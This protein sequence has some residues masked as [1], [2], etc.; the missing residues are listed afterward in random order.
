MKTT[1]QINEIAVALATAQGNMGAALKDSQNPHFRSTY[2]D[3]ASVV[4]A[5]RPHLSAV[6]IATVQLPTINGD[7][8]EVTTA[9]VHKSG[10]VIATTLSA[11]SKDLSPQGIGS[12][13]TY[14][15][16]YG[17]MAVAGI[18]PDDDDGEA[19]MGRHPARDDRRDAPPQRREEPT[20]A[21]DPDLASLIF[22]R[23]RQ[24]NIMISEA[25]SKQI[26]ETILSKSKDLHGSVHALKSGRFDQRF[27]ELE[28]E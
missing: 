6:G 21:E 16:R 20:P 15:R 17:L 11:R 13:I 10:Q 3:L 7:L 2:A 18:A 19:A 24:M 22:A 27:R 26:A 8:V 5:T 1:E 12:A 28:N 4:D 25:R 9:L 14:L 23:C